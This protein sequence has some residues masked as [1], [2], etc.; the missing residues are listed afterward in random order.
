MILSQWVISTHNISFNLMS[1]TYFFYGEIM[2]IIPKLSSNTL[3]CSTD[4]DLKSM[5]N[6]YP[7][8]K[9]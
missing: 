6:E 8:R 2:T 7:Q 1:T 9:F 5:N 3:I 4:N